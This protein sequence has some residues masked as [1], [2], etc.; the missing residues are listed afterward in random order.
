MRLSSI[1][2][3]SGGAVACR[4]RTFASE[5]NKKVRLDL[6]LQ[7][8]EAC[9]FHSLDEPRAVPLRLVC[10]GAILIRDAKVY[11]YHGYQR[12]EQGIAHDGHDRGS[13]KR[14]MLHKGN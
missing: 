2:S 7:H 5:L 8:L 4:L 9:L 1:L 11:E 12:A 13:E 10:T 3:A 14:F 6:C